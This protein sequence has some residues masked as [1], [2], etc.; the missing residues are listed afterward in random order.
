[1]ND[2]DH[3]L[4]KKR[5]VNDLGIIVCI[6]IVALCV[7]GLAGYRADSIPNVPKWDSIY[8]LYLRCYLFGW[9][10]SVITATWGI[11]KLVVAAFLPIWTRCYAWSLMLSWS[12]TYY[13]I[14]RKPIF[15][16]VLCRF[17]LHHFANSSRQLVGERGS[18]R[19]NIVQSRRNRIR[20]IH[21]SRNGGV[22]AVMTVLGAFAINPA[23]SIR[24]STA[25]FP[26]VI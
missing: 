25:S 3:F 2:H 18:R 4:A 17:I 14:G 16:I 6:Q 22:L 21:N 12:L 7:I 11:R 15:T 26:A 13:S 8:L 10:V 5:L 24:R 23:P 20:G 19:Y 1:M 9:I